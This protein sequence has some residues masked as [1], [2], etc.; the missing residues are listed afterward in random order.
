VNSPE[1]REKVV[2]GTNLERVQL[3]SPG[4]QPKSPEV[5]PKSPEVIQSAG[6]LKFGLNIAEEVYDVVG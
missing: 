6:G 5:Q 2:L 4:V 3:K 1:G